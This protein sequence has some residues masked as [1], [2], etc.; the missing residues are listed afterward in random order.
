MDQK[1]MGTWANQYF[2][3]KKFIKIKKNRCPK[4][5]EL[6]SGIIFNDGLKCFKW[7][8]IL[9]FYVFEYINKYWRNKIPLTIWTK[10]NPIFQISHESTL[11]RWSPVGRHQQRG[12]FFNFFSIR[13][14]HSVRILLGVDRFADGFT[15]VGHNVCRFNPTPSR[16]LRRR[17]VLHRWVE[18]ENSFGSLEAATW[19]KCG[20][21]ITSPDGKRMGFLL[22]ALYD[23]VWIFHFDHCLTNIWGRVRIHRREAFA[24]RNRP[25]T[26]G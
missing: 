21:K 14:H 20:E 4:I 26:E 11:Y 16:S 25:R 23:N 15:D 17:Q 3:I 7:M 22:V 19:R 8:Y 5:W 10:T 6:L 18:R 12:W 13:S 24:Y 1:C 2:V 9:H